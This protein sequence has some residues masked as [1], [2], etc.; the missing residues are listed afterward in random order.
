MK[1]ERFASHEEARAVGEARLEAKLQEA[2]E[3]ASERT[4]AVEAA[5]QVSDFTP[6]QLFTL[7]LKNV[8]SRM[9]SLW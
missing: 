1:Q 5:R 8:Q 6:S 7:R 2:A 3:R 4:A 9:W